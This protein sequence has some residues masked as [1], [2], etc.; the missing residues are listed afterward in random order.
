MHGESIIVTS[1]AKAA[2]WSKPQIAAEQCRLLTSMLLDD[3]PGL[4]F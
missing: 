3:T 2:S 1:A 4:T